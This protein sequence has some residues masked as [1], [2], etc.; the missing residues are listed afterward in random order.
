MYQMLSEVRAKAEYKRKVN[1]YLKLPPI[2]QA[3]IIDDEF[4][5]V[6]KEENFDHLTNDLW[7]LNLEAKSMKFSS[8]FRHI[9][10][11]ES[12]N[13]SLSVDPFQSNYSSLQLEP[14]HRSDS[15]KMVNNSIKNFQKP[16]Q[17]RREGK[18]NLELEREKYLKALQA[19]QV[20]R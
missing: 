8:I 17:K 13:P 1:S 4:W 20:L 19:K 7:I 2:P 15:L 11:L 18:S 12:F 5:K 16:P 6:S 9:Q 14:L 3:K 10:S